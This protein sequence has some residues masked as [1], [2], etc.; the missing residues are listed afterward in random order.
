MGQNHLGTQNLG[1]NLRLFSGIEPSSKNG[2]TTGP[3]GPKIADFRGPGYPGLFF[4]IAFHDL[5]RTPGPGGKD[6]SEKNF[7]RA[8]PP[9]LKSKQIAEARR[10]LQEQGSHRLHAWHAYLFYGH[11]Q[12]KHAISYYIS[13]SFQA[14][15]QRPCAHG[16]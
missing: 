5:V 6:A 4:E 3:E 14:F 15:A 16:S 10:L 1:G 11:S 13:A 9:L 12:F 7:S 8:P 2:A